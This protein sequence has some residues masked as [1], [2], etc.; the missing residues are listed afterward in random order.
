MTPVN[1]DENLS[2]KSS[3]IVI[4]NL[5]T[6]IAILAIV[7]SLLAYKDHNKSFRGIIKIKIDDRSGYFNFTNL[8]DLPIKLTENRVRFDLTLGGES[9]VITGKIASDS[10]TMSSSKKHETIARTLHIVNL[11]HF[12]V[13][14]LIENEDILLMDA[15]LKP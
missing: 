11:E 7:V 8:E 1:V 9:Y 4:V 2:I 14:P 3:K 13:I 5:I 6:I 12:E 15:D 10:I